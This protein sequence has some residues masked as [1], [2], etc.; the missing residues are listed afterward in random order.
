[1]RARLGFS[2]FAVL[3]S[4]AVPA[5]IHGRAQKTANSN[6]TVPMA[7]YTDP[8]GEPSFE[9]P[10]VWKADTSAK[11]YIAPHILQ[12]GASPQAQ[13][14]F[15][16]A[17]NYYAKTTLTALVFVYLKL[18]EPSQEACTAQAL[19]SIPA[20]ADTLLINGVSFHH[21]DTGDAGMCHGADQHV[22]WTYRDGTCYLFEGD[23]HTSCSGAYEGQRELTDTEKRALNRHL[24]AIPQSIRFR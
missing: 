13:V 23:V 4:F 8:S 16:P 2:C 21:F 14:I 15:W 20:K 9:Y 24:S 10:V 5:A 1:V 12:A 19:S 6:P 22:Y 18:P 17:G 11:F 3:F 7:T